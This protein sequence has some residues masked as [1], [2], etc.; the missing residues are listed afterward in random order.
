MFSVMV[1]S[2]QNCMMVLG[3]VLLSISNKM[4]KVRRNAED[5]E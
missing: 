4:Q 5:R 2:R 1:L 3:F